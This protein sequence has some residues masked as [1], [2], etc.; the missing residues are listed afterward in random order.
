ML[1]S[2]LLLGLLALCGYATTAPRP[3]RMSDMYIWDRGG[4]PPL[5]FIKPTTTPQP[6]LAHHDSDVHEAYDADERTGCYREKVCSPQIEK[7]CTREGY[8]P[9]ARDVELVTGQCGHVKCC[10]PL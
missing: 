2:H 3:S 6:Q 5:S 4:I 1:A 10:I 9:I 8:H 7:P